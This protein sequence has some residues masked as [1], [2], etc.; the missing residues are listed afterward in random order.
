MGTTSSQVK[1]QG[2]GPVPAGLFEL[3]IDSKAFAFHF[4]TGF[5]A[6]R[7]TKL[8]KSGEWSPVEDN[9]FTQEKPYEDPYV[10]IYGDN[11]RKVNIQVKTAGVDFMYQT[12]TRKPETILCHSGVTPLLYVR[13]LLKRQKIAVGLHTVND[14]A[15]IMCGNETILIINLPD[16][17]VKDSA[18]SPDVMSSGAQLLFLANRPMP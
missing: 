2:S 6:I 18:V 8:S 1:C 3:V 17:K 10:K 4:M 14:D 12:L 7:V 5:K 16:D 15:V 13:M 9:I 11:N